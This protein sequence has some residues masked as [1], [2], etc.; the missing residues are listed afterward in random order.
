MD[1]DSTVADFDIVYDP[2]NVFAQ[3]EDGQVEA[4][5]YDVDT[6]VL[7]FSTVCADI[8]SAEDGAYDDQYG[9]DFSLRDKSHSPTR[10]EITSSIQVKGSPCDASDTLERGSVEL[11]LYGVQGDE[12][13][14]CD[15]SNKVADDAVNAA[16]HSLCA[17][18]QVSDFG[19]SSLTIVDETLTRTSPGA[20][21]ELVSAPFFDPS[22][23]NSDLGSRIE[24]S[25][26]HGLTVANDSMKTY[27]LTVVWEQVLS[28]GSRRLLR[29]THVF[30][31]GEK[32][33]KS[34]IFILPASAQIEDA[35][36][37][38]DAK[39]EEAAPK[40]EEKE[41]DS[42]LSDLE[43]GLIAGGSAL[44][45]LGAGYMIWKREKD[46]YSRM[47]SP[48]EPRY[49]AVRRSERFSTMNF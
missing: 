22:Y 31:A 41:E 45:V 35:A 48:G 10:L 11:D 20:E 2:D 6:R 38:L 18:L 47:D 43:I 30:G 32:T 15:T 49:S 26:A 13:V 28:T 33:A 21:P 19:S 25:S 3:L 46:G 37:S 7:T 29:T 39:S 36:G 17:S 8:C 27:T 1:I 12:T 42:G 4:P 5:V 14:E 16:D 44:V 23:T 40:E 34:S 24:S 9:L